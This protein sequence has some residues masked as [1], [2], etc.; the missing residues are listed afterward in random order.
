MSTRF[1]HVSPSISRHNKVW[2]IMP[3]RSGV[4]LPKLHSADF[5]GV[6][7]LLPDDLHNSFSESRTKT[8]NADKQCYHSFIVNI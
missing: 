7:V 1:V 5:V 2:H 3:A 8:N 4:V 6:F